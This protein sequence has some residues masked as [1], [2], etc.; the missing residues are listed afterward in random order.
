MSS[1]L[2]KNGRYQVLYTNEK[3]GQFDQCVF[4]SD[5]KME[6]IRKSWKYRSAKVVDTKEK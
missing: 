4:S 3:M 5:D 1:T 2:K 6:A